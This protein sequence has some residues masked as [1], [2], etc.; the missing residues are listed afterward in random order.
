MIDSE[1]SVKVRQTAPTTY[2]VEI[3]DS[4]EAF[5]YTASKAGCTV[6]DIVAQAVVDARGKFNSPHSVATR[7]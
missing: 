1:F 5:E 4:S 2:E 7:I 3:V 6:A